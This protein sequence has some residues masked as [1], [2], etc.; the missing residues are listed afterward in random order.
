MAITVKNFV[1]DFKA[2]KIMNTTIN[3]NAVADYI[4]KTLEVKKY[5]PFNLKRQVVEMVVKENITIERGV[6]KS[7]A[8]SQYVSFVVAMLQ[9]HTNLEFSDDPTADYDVLAESGLLASVIETFKQSY[10][11]CDILLKMALANELEDNNLE[12]LI[13]RFLDELLDMA[14]DITYSIENKID[15]IDVQKIIGEFLKP[16]DLE[17]LSV[18]LKKYSK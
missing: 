11:E 7:D 9:A 13:G 14:D 8:I 10:D 1:E 12:A 6:K 3:P 2:K 5:L 18:F 4:E 16:E 17:K 15:G